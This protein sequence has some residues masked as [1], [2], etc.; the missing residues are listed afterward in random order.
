MKSSQVN[1]KTGQL[2]PRFKSNAMS[3]NILLQNGLFHSYL[4]SFPFLQ[5]GER[6]RHGSLEGVKYYTTEIFSRFSV[7][8]TS[9][10]CRLQQVDGH[11]RWHSSD[12]AQKLGHAA[13]STRS[14]RKG[15]QVELNL[16]CN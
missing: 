16:V 12:S 8:E 2:Q 11:E 14:K 7:E 4:F 3:L 9:L 5:T 15:R 6:K 10:K 13:E 1:I